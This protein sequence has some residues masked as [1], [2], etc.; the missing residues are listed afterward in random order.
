MTLCTKRF[1]RIISVTKETR[2]KSQDKYLDKKE[3][4]FLIL[5]HRANHR[6]SLFNA[7]YLNNLMENLGVL[8]DAR[9]LL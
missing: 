6:G 1:D 2:V 7:Q 4:M 8:I 3:F 5:I 9:E